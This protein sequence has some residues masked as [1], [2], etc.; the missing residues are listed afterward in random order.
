MK[1]TKIRKDSRPIR[2]H[3]HRFAVTYP[4]MDLVTSALTQRC[5]SPRA[6]HQRPELRPHARPSLTCFYLY[7]FQTRI[8]AH[9]PWPYF[10]RG[11]PQPRPAIAID[12]GGTL[13]VHASHPHSPHTLTPYIGDLHPV[14][15][16]AFTHTTPVVH[17]LHN[18]F[19]KSQISASPEACSFSLRLLLFALPPCLWTGWC[20]ALCPTRVPCSKTILLCSRTP[21]RQSAKLPAWP[22]ALATPALTVPISLCPLCSRRSCSG[23]EHSLWMPA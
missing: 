10:W 15:C 18:S 4:R 21:S 6:N 12:A 8:H 11:F 7:P 23:H 19:H 2:R 1:Y 3:S 16:P 5:R 13:H 22:P 9:R 14:A 20:A 17:H